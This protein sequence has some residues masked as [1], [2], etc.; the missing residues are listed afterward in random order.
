MSSKISALPAATSV[1]LADLLTILQGGA[2]KKTTKVAMFLAASGE[3]LFIQ[4]PVAG[5]VGVDSSGN[6]VCDTT[7]GFTAGF[8]TGGTHG[9]TIDASGNILIHG[10]PALGLTC[11][12]SGSQMKIVSGGAITISSFGGAGTTVEFQAP[13]SSYW[14]G[15]PSDLQTAIDRIAKVVSA[16]GVTPIP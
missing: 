15:S 8:T 3:N 7:A 13:H 10:G 5:T 1:G 11:E 9:L 6:V 16:N 2:N 4:G 14:S 12:S